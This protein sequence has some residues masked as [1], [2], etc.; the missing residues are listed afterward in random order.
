MIVCYFN[1]EFFEGMLVI[2]GEMGVGKFIVIDVFGF[3][4]GY[5]FE[6]SMICNGVDKVDIIVIF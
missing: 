2:I 5:W 6:S 1:F 4:L 3:C